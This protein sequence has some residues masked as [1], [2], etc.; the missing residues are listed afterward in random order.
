MFHAVLQNGIIMIGP[1]GRRETPE[2]KRM[3]V[4]GSRLVLTVKQLISHPDTRR[5]CILNEE[6]R[7]LDIPVRTA[8]PASPAAA[9]EAPLLAAIDA[10]AGLVKECT[11]EVET[12]GDKPEPDCGAGGGLQ[13]C[14]GAFIAFATVRPNSRHLARSSAAGCH[15][16]RMPGAT[17]VIFA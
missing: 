1:T 2:K 11:I 15:L 8:D 6:T 13:S 9:I 12:A 10:I 17:L 14:Y 7:L 16:A 4:P 5:I 3:K